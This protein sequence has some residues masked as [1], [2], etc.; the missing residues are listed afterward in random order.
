MNDITAFVLAL[1]CCQALGAF[2]GALAAVWGEVSF[3]V[4]MH[5]G[6]VE[7]AEKIFSL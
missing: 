7:K 6:N 5:N 2:I 4:A 3:I 1:L